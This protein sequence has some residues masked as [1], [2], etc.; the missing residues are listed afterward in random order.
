MDIFVKR[1]V[2]SIVI[3]LVLVIAGV[4]AALRIPV[5]QFPRIESSSLII[6]TLY[7]GSSAE[8]V[9]GF[10]TDPVERAAMATP[11]IDFVDSQTSAGSSTVTAWLKLNEDSTA[12]LAELSARLDQIRFELPTAA[13][14]PSI[15]VR[16]T[17]RPNAL[18]YLDVRHQDGARAQLTDYITREIS[19]TL[20]S[21][22]GV[23]RV[24]VEGGRSPAM[25]IWVDPTRLAGLNLGASEVVNALKENNV[26]AAIG[27]TKNEEQQIHLLSNA[28]LRTVEDFEN[29]VIRK[30]DDTFIQLS[31]VARVELGEDRGDIDARTD[32]ETTVYVSVWPLP[33]AN[34]IAI[35]NELYERLDQISAALP[36]GMRIGIAHDGTVYMRQALREVFTTLGETVVLV[37]LVVLVLMGS[38]RSALVP[39]VTIPISVLGSVAAMYVVGFS[40]NLLTVLAIVL[41]IGLVVDDAIVVVENV[42]RHLREGKS[43]WEA[44]LVSSRELFT[45]VVAMTLTLAAVY[46]PIGF[47]SGL[48]GS[49]FKEFAFSLS[50]AV[51]NSGVVA[52]TLS[53]IMSAR[54]CQDRGNEA[55]GT[56]MVNVPF[57]Y[58]KAA[59]GAALRYVFAWR[60]QVLVVSTFLSLLII[61]L[62]LFSARELAPVEDQGSI[63]V[64]VESPPEATLEFTS[65]QMNHVV[66]TL[67]EAPEFHNM[68]QVVTPNSAFGGMTL[69]DY[70]Q[71]SR[72]T[73]ELMPWVFQR[74]SGTPALKVLPVLEPSLPSAGNYDVE[75][76]VQGSDDYE[77]LTEYADKLI[78]RAYESNQFL[79]AT[80]DLKVDLP[81]ARLQLDHDKLANLGMN[82]DA[83]SE[84]LSLLISE[85]DINRFNADGK[86]Y[87]VIPIV[88]TSAT[89]D[90]ESLLDLQLRTPDGVLIPARSVMSVD[91]EVGPRVLGKFNQRRSFRI[92]A[93]VMPGTTKDQALT[94]LEAVAAD[95]LPAGYSID[96]A[97]NSRQLRAEGNSLFSVLLIALVIVYLML[98]VQ[99]DSFR[100][101]L[102][103]VLGSVPLALSASLLCS[104]LGM[105]TINIYSQIGCITL[106]GL[107]AKNGILI[108][109][110]ASTLQEQGVC[111]V[112]A[113]LT[114]AQL[115]LRPILM[116]TAATV[117][118]HFPLLLVTDAGAEARNSIG[119]VL[120]SGMFVGTVF[121]LF[122]LPCVYL[123]LARESE[124]TVEVPAPAQ[125]STADTSDSSAEKGRLGLAPVPAAM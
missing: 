64:I 36:D 12:A 45:P 37:G 83:V 80:T 66:N 33:G 1:P 70:D 116:T 98:A 19:P 81:Q 89:Q 121:T 114:A 103:V 43:R 59:Y 21:I 120:V 125:A 79:F 69:L 88:E 73:H 123:L 53:P 49:L 84:Q 118:G 60:P 90:P 51:I 61:P 115:R 82:S 74:M 110:F 2:L 56:R 31:D 50:I 32:N 7:P 95:V 39:L 117:I 96:Y 86:A 124:S 23:Q 54:V 10:I 63:N 101:P 18:F 30:V 112:E 107:V 26:I 78:Q 92:Q 97:G 122:V 34:E 40:L 48:T 52:I 62:Y 47:V 3:C 11:G 42:A 87:R 119:V 44:A 8:V 111:K 72:S 104:F 27:R 93:G 102:V 58:L 17:D 6:T 25:R 85:Q 109:E 108:T 9:Q 24:G 22:N 41:S 68:W 4:W 67:K 106:V 99:F 113:V 20:N 35:G 57:D 100:L 76:V 38:L 28:T 15:T 46:A 55:W 29:L 105:T 94:T 91:Y 14:D 75:L 5:L 13:E 65:S 16:R 77:A 71:R